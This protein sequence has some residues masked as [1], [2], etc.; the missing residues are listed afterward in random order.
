MFALDLQDIWQF[1][2]ILSC[3]F[4][5]SPWPLLSFLISSNSSSMSCVSLL[6]T[7]L[8]CLPLHLSAACNR[9]HR[10]RPDGDD[11]QAVPAQAHHCWH[12][13][14]C[15]PHWLRPHQEGAQRTLFI[16]N[17][18][19]FHP[20]FLS[21]RV[22]HFTCFLHLLSCIRKVRP[23]FALLFK[24]RSTFP[25]NCHTHTHNCFPT[26]SSNHIV[27][28]FCPTQGTKYWAFTFKHQHF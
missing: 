18:P 26:T 1:I 3:C 9:T 28:N 16:Q 11:G 4:L 14:L 8:I 5:F 15:P 20:I 24:T 7:A 12:Q 21:M 10:L 19:S 17:S 2:F 22:F 13:C 23:A 27:T 6:F 25:L